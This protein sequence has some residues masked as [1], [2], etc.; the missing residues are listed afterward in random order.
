MFFFFLFMAKKTNRAVPLGGVLVLLCAA[1]PKVHPA[2]VVSVLYPVAG[3]QAAGSA[4]QGGSG[5][6]GRAWRRQGEG[7]DDDVTKTGR[8]WNLTAVH[9]SIM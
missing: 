5:L 9:V 4:A 1:S 3:G 7:D 6:V 2:E 8:C